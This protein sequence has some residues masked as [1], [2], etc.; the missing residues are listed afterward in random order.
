MS[1]DYSVY[2]FKLQMVKGVDFRFGTAPQPGNELHW[3]VLSRVRN[4]KVEF[5]NALVKIMWKNI[6][7]ALTVSNCFNSL[8]DSKLFLE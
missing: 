8:T 5:S 6:Q 3:Q 7:N 1:T 2:L 4:G